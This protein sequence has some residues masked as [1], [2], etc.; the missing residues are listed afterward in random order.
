MTGSPRLPTR[1]ASIPCRSCGKLI[2]RR[3]NCPNCSRQPAPTA[4]RDVDPTGQSHGAGPRGPHGGNRSHEG[5]W[6]F[7][8]S[9]STRSGRRHL[10]L[11]LGWISRVATGAWEA[12]V[13]AL[14]WVRRKLGIYH[15]E[16]PLLTGRITGQELVVRDRGDRPVWARLARGLLFVPVMVLFAT[17]MLLKAAL[18]PLMLAYRLMSGSILNFAGMGKAFSVGA[19]AG[20][21]GAGWILDRKRKSM[22][23]FWEI[24]CNG[25]RRAIRIPLPEDHGHDVKV[26]DQ[27]EVWGRQHPDGT[28]RATAVVNQRNSLRLAPG[29]IPPFFQLLYALG[30][31]ALMVILF[32]WL[33]SFGLVNGI[34]GI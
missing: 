20:A 29:F 24:D 1:V 27:V 23:C 19:F 11:N 31:V 32:G 10:E 34:G 8:A 3:G 2:A 7:E 22:V 6:R 12:V 9:R 16:L 30:G 25:A 4:G 5:A 17:L 13:T 15:G 21:I 28:I 18:F 14:L 33:G 26:G